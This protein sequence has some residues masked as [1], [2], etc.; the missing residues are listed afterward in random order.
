MPPA[1][2]K[3]RPSIRFWQHFWVTR[4]LLP[5]KVRNFLLSFESMG[6]IKS[7]KRIISRVSAGNWL[8]WYWRSNSNKRHKLTTHT[9]TNMLQFARNSRT[10][11]HM[12]CTIYTIQ[13]LEHD[14]SVTSTTTRITA[15]HEQATPEDCTVRE[16]LLNTG[17]FRRL[18][19]L[20]SQVIF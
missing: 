18:D 6:W 20:P 10:L 2:V 14:V 5:A 11:A 4:L 12:I 9:S 1:D 13:Y 3:K 15:A 16:K 8:H 19:H 7:R 17:C